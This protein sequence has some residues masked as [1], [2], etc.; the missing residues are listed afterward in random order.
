MV[1]E[2]LKMKKILLI[3]KTLRKLMNAGFLKMKKIVLIFKT[4][5]KNEENF[6]HF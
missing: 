3:F 2:L 5:P 1:T 6:A 4:V